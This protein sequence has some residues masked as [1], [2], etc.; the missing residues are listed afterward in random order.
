MS[1]TTGGWFL[2]EDSRAEWPEGDDLS[3]EVLDAI[4]DLLYVVDRR[5]RFV[6]WND[7]FPEV[8]GYTDAEI[9]ELHE[10]DIIPDEYESEATEALA[11]VA[12]GEEVTLEAPLVT[13]AGERIPHEFTASPLTDEDGEI[14]GMVGTARDISE[15]LETQQQLRERERRF[16][17]LV[18]NVPGMMYR[19]R[20]EPGWPVE[21]VSEGCTELTGYDSEALEAAAVSWGTDVVHPEDRPRLWGR[22]QRAIDA[23]EPFTVTYRIITSEGTERWVWEQGRCVETEGGV[24][25]LE[26]FV[27]D[28]TER[29][30]REED[31]ERYERLIEAIGD[32]MYV[33]DDDLRVREA[34]EAFAA[35]FGLDREAALGTHLSE[36]VS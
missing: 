17:T 14:W 36:F 5:G 32:A 25:V 7:R 20:N 35:M 30:H 23:G 9:A 21:F 6:D 19:C 18:S 31:L 3:G 34:N 16:S 13:K 29:K 15:L 11:T 2:D 4:S 26:G 24:E 8:T 27:T 22:I 1:N 12:A 10:F 33:V 28:I